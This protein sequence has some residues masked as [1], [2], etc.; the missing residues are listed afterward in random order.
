MSGDSGRTGKTLTI[1]R[2]VERV[3]PANPSARMPPEVPVTQ[4]VA[5]GRCA[6]AGSRH[7]CSGAKAE[8]AA[9]AAGHRQS[10][11]LAVSEG[12]SSETSDS[13]DNLSGAHSCRR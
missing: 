11:R 2:P 12:G 13:T 5:S 6:G 4:N 1:P 9:E 7:E 3:L 10:L 8:R